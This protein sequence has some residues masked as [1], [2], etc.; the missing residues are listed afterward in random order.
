MGSAKTLHIIIPTII[1]P[2]GYRVAKI[3][4]FKTI[5]PN[6]PMTRITELILFAPNRVHRDTNS[7]SVHGSSANHPNTVNS[8][9]TDYGNYLFHPHK[10]GY[11]P[12][13]A[14]YTFVYPV[15]TINILKIKI[16]TK[17]YLEKC[18]PIPWIPILDIKPYSAVA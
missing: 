12:I 9:N 14:W 1:E 2:D 6:I 8:E 4:K 5:L 16:L 11:S 15:Y 3:H 17:K 7:H 13:S 10:E 18:I